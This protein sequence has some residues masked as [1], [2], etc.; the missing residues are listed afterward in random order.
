MS[1]VQ[2]CPDVS[3]LQRLL[4]G[5]L[6]DQD[7]GELNA[8][9]SECPACQERLDELIAGQGFW[10][11]VARNL[12]S[13]H[14]E[15]EAGTAT[16]FAARPGEASDQA[17]DDLT[18][19]FLQQS[20]KPDSLGRL[21]HYEVLEVIG[22]GGMGIV[23]R[24]FDEKLHRVVAIKVMA[25]LLAATSPPR[26]RFLRE[27]RA[28]A[29]VRHEHVVDIHAVE[30]QPIPH[31]VMEYVP[32]ESLQQRLDRIG[33]LEV[34]D[35]LRIGQ[36]IARGLAAAHAQGLTHRD[37]KPGNMLLE[38][39][40]E[41]RV[42][43][44]DFGLAR[45]ADDASLTQSGVI[46][47]TP[48]YMA[49]EQAQGGTID[50]RADLFSFGSVLY[51]MC[52]GRP[53][54]RA[55]TSL[56]VLKRVVEDAPRPIQEI[57]PEVPQW[58]C[59]IIS[60]LH[61]KRPADRFQSAKEVADLL[62]RCQKEFEQHGHVSPIRLDSAHVA[63]GRADVLQEIVE[64]VQGPVAGKG[65]AG[66]VSLPASPK[67]RATD[68]PRLPL[69]NWVIAATA[70]LLLLCVLSLSEATGVTQVAATVI[71]LLTPQGTLV[72][73][74]DDPDVKVT[75]EGD[76]GLVITGAGLHEV[77][78]KPGSYQLRAD[79][80][81]LP[82]P[83]D[84]DLITITRGD[85]QVV[86]VR[87]QA[88]AP[89]PVAPS[90]VPGAFVLRGGKRVAER[91]FDTLA[92]AVQSANDGDT[93]EVRGNGPF[94]CQLIEIS[95]R[96][97]TIRA[98]EGFRPRLLF[99]E[100]LQTSAPLVLEGLEL[101]RVGQK[102][103]KG[104][105]ESLVLAWGSPSL[106]I[107]NCR[108]REHLDLP[109]VRSNAPN[110]VLRNCEFLSLDRG[111]VAL[112]PMRCVIDN[113][114]V[115]GRGLLALVVEVRPEQPDASV[116]ITRSTVRSPD[117]AIFLEL[118]PIQ[119]DKLAEREIRRV[120]VDTSGTIL[121][122]ALSVV[123]NE[124]EPF[125]ARVTPQPEDAKALL[126]RMLGWRDRSNLY[127]PGGSVLL[128]NLAPQGVAPEIGPRSLADWKQLWSS[129]DEDAVEGIVKYQGGD[130]LAKLRTAPEKLTPDDFRLRPDSAG[131][132][133]GKGG[134]DLGADID[135][136][137]P[138]AAYE[139]WKKMPEYQEW[140]KEIGQKKSNESGVR[141]KESENKPTPT[142]P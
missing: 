67:H 61:A 35:V 47:G 127:A 51:T 124:H 92:E 53:P 140:L 93:I 54:F 87:L 139:R 4:D 119:T 137:G 42:K 78:L 69:R 88:A 52:S 41:E 38:K 17:D 117:W 45:A 50:H 30:E 118:I 107:A 34:L 43:I 58:L 22:R 135:L 18:L 31:L 21:A 123:M 86:R 96:A 108:F 106:H 12:K 16:R 101:Q 3:H 138:G 29:Q 89:A 7:Q 130:L 66:G 142:D 80:N 114:L 68:V 104:F 64:D 19:E 81:G 122:A 8:H 37:V 100:N 111:A 13:A 72:I 91:R 2:P 56:A 94:V 62:S 134:K 6:A 33:P 59:D 77:R 9:L 74:T 95:V 10:S 99:A 15:I 121:D 102:E 25:P 36:Q 76:G 24:A 1:D 90:P 65:R 32:G 49:P 71:H 115:V 85:K 11:D 131:Y 110:C 83:L 132:Q 120:R 5:L 125:L 23:L 60:K 105:E 14:S 75:I 40:I 97:L 44:T 103:P 116:Q 20:D 63:E 39:G 73:E 129:K 27:A 141:D 57:I 48:L 98:A 112:D 46:A 26:K 28:A 55:P 109:C 82:V 113:C 70:L 133:S 79:K 126:L 84:Q 128:W 136:V